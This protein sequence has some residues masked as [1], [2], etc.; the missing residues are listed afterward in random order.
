MRSLRDVHRPAELEDAF[1]RR[2]GPDPSARRQPERV[3]L[4]CEHASERLPAP[5]VWPIADRSL[6]GT[7]WAHDLGAAALTRELAQ[8]L[9][10]PAVLSRFTRLLADPNREEDHP[11]LFR[12]TAEGGRP[13]ALNARISAAEKERRLER[14]YRPFH[15][16]I[17]AMVAA[18]EAPVLLS[19]HTFTPL[20][21]GQPRALELGVLY[22]RE[23]ALGEAIDA[24]LRAAGFAS[25]RNEPYS[26]KEG[27]I[28]SADLHA[29]AHERRALELEVRQDLAVQPAFRT[30]FVAALVDALAAT[31]D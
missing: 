31:L 23:D 24:R 8:A 29:T 3:T 16:A 25:R 2:P 11:D 26:G 22:D 28:F 18:S 27:L 5:W 1:E 30:R 21:E 17:D 10:A 4:T 14:T 19:V 12:R 6:Q 15:A 20:Y 7:H 13:V 9:E